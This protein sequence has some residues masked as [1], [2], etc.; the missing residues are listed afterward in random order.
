MYIPR[1]F[2]INDQQQI[3]AFLQRCDFATLV[4][5]P[6]TGMVAT[7][8]PLIVRRAAGLVLA[9][10]VARANA[11]WSSMNGTD[12]ALAIFMGPHAYVS[13]TWYA[14]APAVP[15][16]NYATVHVYGKPKARH[17]QAFTEDL[18]RALVL[19]HEEGP[20][21]WRVEAQAPGFIAG[22]TAAIVAFEMPVDRIE[23]QFKLG[24]NR[25]EEDRAG[26][27]AGLL[28]QPSPENAALAAFMSSRQS[29]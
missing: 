22:L 21:P 4:S 25:S 28:S 27:L 5:A 8:V 2:E 14:S 10:H 19:R 26:T 18:L 23:A 11:Q 24:Q 6:A 15:T 13:P 12:E 1:A 7:H 3:E 16:W 17:D 20:H 9:G 29:G